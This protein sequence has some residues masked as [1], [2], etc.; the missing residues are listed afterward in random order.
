[1]LGNKTKQK[2]LHTWLQ[3]ITE[4]WSGANTSWQYIS[5]GGH[6]LSG[7]TA[8]LLSTIC[9]APENFSS[10][11]TGEFQVRAFLLESVPE[12]YCSIQPPPPPHFL[13]SLPSDSEAFGGFLQGSSLTSPC[14]TG[15]AATEVPLAEHGNVRLEC[16]FMRP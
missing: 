8:G 2:S 5:S 13:L 9:S 6:Q 4:C 1:M 14:R 11:S 12:I 15:F 7:P 3:K 16:F 10:L